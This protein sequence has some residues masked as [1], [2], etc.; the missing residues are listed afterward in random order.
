MKITLATLAQ[1]TEQE[2]YDQIVGHLRQQGEKSVNPVLYTRCLYRNI[3]GLKCGAGDLIADNEYSP[4]MDNV[5]DWLHL[6]SAKLV[7]DTIHNDL[8]MDLQNSH[9]S[10]TVEGW[11][12]DFKYVATQHNLTYKEPI[13]G[14]SN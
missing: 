6:I 7:P 4:E 1:A 14:T 3:N 13:N 5:G 8:I 2:V 12:E 10:Y 9:D 11:E